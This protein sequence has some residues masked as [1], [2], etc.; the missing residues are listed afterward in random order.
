MQGTKRMIFQSSTPLKIRKFP[1]VT[2]MKELA[3]VILEQ[4]KIHC[5]GSSNCAFWDFLNVGVTERYVFFLTPEKLWERIILLRKSKTIFS[6]VRLKFKKV[7]KF[8]KNIEKEQFVAVTSEMEY[9]L[10]IK[11]PTHR[12]NFYFIKK[13]LFL[14]NKNRN[15]ST[16]IRKLVKK[17]LAGTWF[18]H[19]TCGLLNRTHSQHICIIQASDDFARRSLHV[20][21]SFRM[22]K[23]V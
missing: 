13:P 14:A 7:S 6:A 10:K 21:G 18:E 23:K 20:M 12:E 9:F 8:S 17:N 15:V 4:N 11:Y 3:S 5:E 2:W 1:N 22:R 16:S 19:G